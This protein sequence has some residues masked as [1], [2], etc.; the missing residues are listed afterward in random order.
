MLGKL[1]KRRS[2][3]VQLTSGFTIAHQQFAFILFYLLLFVAGVFAMTVLGHDSTVPATMDEMIVLTR[4]V[5][6]GAQRRAA[7]IA[8]RQRH[9]GAV[10]ID[11][12]ARPVEHGHADRCMVDE[13]LELVRG[14]RARGAG[15]VET[16]VMRT[17]VP[18]PVKFAGSSGSAL[19]SA[20]W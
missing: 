14:D 16:P 19:R 13:A 5:N 8:L 11:D 17:S 4:A 18:V 3:V 20:S 2:F 12:D 15:S 9:E 10:G 6:R 7:H 1:I